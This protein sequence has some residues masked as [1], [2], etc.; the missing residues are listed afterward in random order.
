LD[1]LLNVVGH[2]KLEVE[3]HKQE[4]DFAHKE[5]HLLQLLDMVVA[6]IQV[7]EHLVDM[8]VL[9]GKV[10]LVGMVVLEDMAD[11][12]DMV[13]LE[14]KVVL[15]GMA[16]LEDMAVLVDM[17]EHSHLVEQLLQVEQLQPQWYYCGDCV[18][19]A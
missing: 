2:H 1:G 13:D 17:V 15:V 8:V 5:Q 19:Y 16:V 9:V 3:L 12:E 10:D 11:L 4:V 14:D 7:E 6:D 18:D